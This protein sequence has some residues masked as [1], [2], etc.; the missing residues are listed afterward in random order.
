MVAEKSQN[1]IQL[2]DREGHP[3]EVLGESGKR[4]GQFNCPS[5]LVE[6][7]Y[8][9]VFVIDTLN[10]RIQKFDPDLN[11]VSKWGIVGK[12]P[13]QF[14]NPSGICLSWEPDWAPQGE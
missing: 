10:Q 13:G 3:L 6:D 7:P 9:Y 1:R 11:F 2:F 4:D 14:Y 5:A 12:D 8:G